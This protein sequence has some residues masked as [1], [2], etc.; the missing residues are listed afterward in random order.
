MAYLAM[1]AVLLITACTGSEHSVE[2]VAAA[3]QAVLDRYCTDCHNRAEQ[4]G[5]LVLQDAGLANPAARA[6]VF[7]SVLHKL[8]LGLM[9]P[10]GEPRPQTAMISELVAW[11]ES[12]LDAAA[13]ASPNPGRMPLHRLNR[14]EYANAIR[15]LLGVDLD[16]ASQ[17][18]ADSRSHGFDNIS[19]VLT[20][21]PLLLERYL[22]VALRVAAAAVGD[23]RTE[24]RTAH[25]QPRPDLSQNQWIEGLPLGTRGGLVVDH[26]FPVDG[27][28]EIRPELWA[29]AASTLRGLEGFQTPF[30]L[31]ILIDGAVVHRAPVG[32]RQD[33]DLSNRD[34]GSA[35]AIVNERIATRVPV[36]AG[37]RRV[38]VTFVARS[39]AINQRILQPFDSDVP[40]GNDAYGWPR[41]L[42]LLVTGPF[43]A[44]GPGETP[45]RRA[46][47]TC[48]PGTAM[49]DTDC[50]QDILA[51]VAGRAWSRPLTDTDT[52]MLLDFYR[53]GRDGLTDTR[54]SGDVAFERGI[55][56]ALARILSGPEFIFRGDGHP[57]EVPP[58]QDYPISDLAL[59]SRLALFLWSSIPDEP[60]LELALADRLREPGVLASEVQRMLADPRARSLVTDFAMQWLQLTTVRTK[61]PDRM[62]FPEFDDNLRQAML[63]ESEMLLEHV[64]L[65]DR[66]VIELLDADYTFLN[67]QLAYHYGVAGVYGDAFRQVT[68]DD[69]QRRGLL[70]HASVLFETS[71]ATRTSPV[72]RGQWIMTNLLNAPPPPPPPDVPELEAVFTGAPQTMRERLA[73]HTADPV[74]ASCHAVMDPPGFALEHFDAL[75]RWRDTDNGLPVDSAAQLP[76]G[77]DISS[78]AALRT[79]LLS[80]PDIFVNTLTQKLMTWALSRGLEAEDLPTVRAIVRDAAVQDYRFSALIL[81]IVEST[82]F[83]MRRRPADGGPDGSGTRT[84]AVADLAATGAG[85]EP[86][87]SEGTR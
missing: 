35:T 14:T 52:A 22:T 80:Q 43:E 70:G 29:A 85:Q 55:Q 47:F 8:R 60:L 25:Y 27:E 30:E 49:T 65:G 19:D 62:T 28:Y 18:P 21:S 45:A 79:A 1:P 57:E 77:T 26:Y 4:A 48:R 41:I 87:I 17:L 33:D 82:Q 78:P 61:A 73:Q 46:L 38:G 31:E 59:A 68:M 81:G 53:Q 32:G 72:F 15:D 74:C 51:R 13:A 84:A 36:A 6:D 5:D 63:R 37:L 75:G 58:G 64:L 67:E 9:P 66:S 56:L 24:P 69:P 10:P 23:T 3:H 34:Q 42:R 7:E 76:D 39:H 11:L 12:S 20:T 83:Q 86:A 2:Q 54:A 44:S 50:A 71:V 16:I 40:A